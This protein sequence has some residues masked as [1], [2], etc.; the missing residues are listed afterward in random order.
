MEPGIQRE[1]RKVEEIL[2]NVGRDD[3][4]YRYVVPSLRYSPKAPG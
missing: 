2:H 3:K 1:V 4:V